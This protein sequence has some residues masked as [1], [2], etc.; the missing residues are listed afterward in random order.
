M[1]YQVHLSLFQIYLF[2][3]MIVTISTVIGSELIML[4]R[5]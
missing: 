1:T 4:D 2:S 5:R 3:F